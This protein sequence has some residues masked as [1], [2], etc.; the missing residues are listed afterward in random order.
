M[1]VKNESKVIERCLETVKPL[2]DYWVIVDT[3]STDGTQ[4]IIK[5]FMKGIPG[6]LHERPWVDFAHNRNEALQL[7]KN[8]S[9]Y[10]LR[11]DADEQL[12]FSKEF[13]KPKLNKDFYYI[14]TKHAGN[15]YSRNQLIKASLNW[16]WVGVLH[17][18]LGCPEAKTHETLKG[19]YNLYG[20]DGCRS[21]DP[22]KFK[23]DA[24]VLEAALKKEP[25]NERYVFYL[26]QS[27]KDAGDHWLAIKYYKKRAEMGGWDQEVYWSLYQIAS[28]QEFL[29]LPEETFTKSFAKAH[30]YRPARAEP[31]YRLAHYYRLNENYISGYL[32]AK[33]ALSIPKS[34]DTIMVES[35]VDEHG[36]L[37]ELSLCA[38]YLGKYEESKEISEK[39]LQVPNLPLNVKQCVLKNLAWIDPKIKKDA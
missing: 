11:I 23:K 18:Y 8:K 10:I 22:E 37:M 14:T 5:Q 35:W 27:Y 30:Q 1:I 17:E 24:K 20:F 29:K 31:L 16:K 26:A 15:T 28:L 25:T 13:V 34:T 7:A 36:L 2:I 4:K 9:D 12:I 19:V 32:L 39:I 6:E 3:G 21:Q 33:Y 38:Y